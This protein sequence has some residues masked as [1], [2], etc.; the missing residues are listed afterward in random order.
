VG[1]GPGRG[2]PCQVSSKS[3]QGFQ[4]NQIKSNLFATKKEHNATQKKQ[5]K[6]VWFGS[7][8]G[9]NLPFSYA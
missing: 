1:C 7:L 8:K 3:V 4:I 6:Y 9:R 5:S 2:Q